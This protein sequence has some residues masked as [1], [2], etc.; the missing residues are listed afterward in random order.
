[1]ELPEIAGRTIRVNQRALLHDISRDRNSSDD[2]AKTPFEQAK[3][4]ISEAN[5]KQREV[6]RRT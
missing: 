2:Q 3:D 6:A 5:G 1:L 4:D